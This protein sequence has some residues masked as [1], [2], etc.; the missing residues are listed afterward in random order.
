MTNIITKANGRP[1]TFGSVV[2]QLFQTN[3]DRFF[4]DRQWGFDGLKN[5]KVARVNILELENRYELHFEAPGWQKDD[6]HLSYSDNTLT[7]SAERPQNGPAQTSGWLRR[8]F[9]IQPFVRTFTMD[10]TV[11]AEKAAARYENG[12]LIVTLPKKEEAK[13]LSRTIDVQ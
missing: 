6:F 4:D 10:E 12:I 1:A 9:Q 3:W 11:D 5:Q 2:D 8:E 7:V 13:R